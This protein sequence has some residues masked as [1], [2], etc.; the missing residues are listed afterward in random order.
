MRRTARTPKRKSWVDS[1]FLA[2]LIMLSVN[3][4]FAALMI[5]VSRYM[6]VK[7]NVFV[8][9][10]AVAILLALILNV[11]FVFAYIRNGSILKKVFLTYGVLLLLIGSVGFYYIFSANSLID[12][13]INTDESETVEYSIVSFNKE[14]TL[15]NMG[16]A[17]VGYIISDQTFESFVKE[18]VNS[19]SKTVSYE[20]YET[21][22]DLLTA[23][24]DGKIQYAVLPK[25]YARYSEAM[26][27]GSEPLK[28]AQTLITFK[29]T[30]DTEVTDVD[31]LK[32]PFTVLIT[33]LN[34]N[35]SDT[36]ILATFNPK[37]MKVTMTSVP[38]DSYVPIACQ[39]NRRDK[40]NHSR[41]IS[42]QC[43]MKSV[44]NYLDVKVDFYFETDFYAVVKVVDALGGL[45]ITSPLTFAGSFPVEGKVNEYKDITVPEGTNL[46][47]GEQVLTFARE[48][49]R[50][51]GGDFQRQMNQQYVLT[52][53]AKK[54]MSTR[55]PNTLLS[56]LDAAKSNIQT[57]FPISDLSALMGYTL[58]QSDASSEK[59]ID[60]VR[61]VNYQILGDGHFL[62]NGM[63]V[64][65]P[66]ESYVR[67]AHRLIDENIATE[68]KL[69]NIY[70]MSFKFSKHYD[71]IQDN[72]LFERNTNV[73]WSQGKLETMSDDNNSASGSGG[74]NN[75]TQ[76]PE[77]QKPE[78]QKPE[79]QKP[80]TQKPQE[81]KPSENAT[82]SVTVP[83][84]DGMTDEQIK[85]WGTKNNITIRFGTVN[86]TNT[87]ELKFNEGQLWSQS[88][89]PNT[90]I[91]KGTLIEIIRVKLTNPGPETSKP[92]TQVQAKPNQE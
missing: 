80:E 32:E 75:Q 71:F 17:H 9:G 64:M 16:P 24:M 48:R 31:V 57:N 35:L 69:L 79:T 8:M 6:Q 2:S 63:W 58:Q 87:A 51:P 27:S 85:A 39:A 68:T 14:N 91:E 67:N 45:E 42:R 84:F 66:Y 77:T 65:L 89:L 34:E 83:N 82:G 19:Y 74:T 47:D 20:G 4:I 72:D 1:K 92:E 46:L 55:N 13:I 54:V 90:E 78:T 53:I 10:I 33:G 38:R 52:E 40:I 23:S 7:V 29:T 70:D 43:L 25:N 62:N 88:V 21:A 56:I 60:F 12:K 50:L 22:V 41:G 5:L 81:E 18:K 61:I 49:K 30:V 36:I 15:E 26:P 28:D 37:D 11:L 76:K 86:K 73:L 3:I 44:E 59:G